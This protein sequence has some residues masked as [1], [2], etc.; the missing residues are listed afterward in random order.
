MKLIKEIFT[1]KT[2]SDLTDY[3]ISTERYKHMKGEYRPKL[4]N[5]F[6][7]QSY[8]LL[9]DDIRKFFESKGFSDISSKGFKYGKSY[10]YDTYWNIEWDYV[11]GLMNLI[12]NGENIE[13]IIEECIRENQKKQYIIGYIPPTKDINHILNN[14][15]LEYNREIYN[16]Y[17]KGLVIKVL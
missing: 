11:C 15:V 2:L 14:E 5:F 3:L 8:E 7:T 10:S 6:K 4:E 16:K 9:L 17:L 13:L 1:E 12:Y